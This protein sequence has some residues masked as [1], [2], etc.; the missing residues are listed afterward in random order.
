MAPQTGPYQTRQPSTPQ[1]PQ[2]SQ[3][4]ANWPGRPMAAVPAPK[5]PAAVE[6]DSPLWLMPAG[7]IPEKFTG[8]EVV[9]RIGSE[10]VLASELLAGVEET[11]QRALEAGQLS[12]AQ[13]PMARHH[14]M[15]QR[16]QQLI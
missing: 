6:Q 12:Q 8:T 9:A 11:I 7:G 1:A 16:L 15:Y 2:S 5:D 14:L 3:R 10:V 4:P 13:V